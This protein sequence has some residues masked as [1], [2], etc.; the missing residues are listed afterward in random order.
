MLINVFGAMGSGKTLFLTLIGYCYKQKGYNV[1]A[2][3]KL[4]FPSKILTL[5]QL[6]DREIP[7]NTVLLLDE[8]YTL[9]ESRLS[10][11]AL[12]ILIS[13]LVFQSRKMNVDIFTTSQLKRSVD[14]RLRDIADYNILAEKHK[15][16]FYY[17]IFFQNEIKTLFLP[18]ENAQKFYN[19]YD[20]T[21]V[22]EDYSFKLK[23]KKLA[24]KLEEELKDAAD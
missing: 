11:S 21:E 9:L 18:F 7:S 14:V 13:H 3:F 15:K 4:K 12:N 8:V 19:L 20:T 24:E 5:N 22:V 10:Y 17:F 6:I 1:F 2:N 16:G 23:R